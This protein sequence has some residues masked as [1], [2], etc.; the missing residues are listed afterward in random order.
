MVTLCHGIYDNEDN[1]YML[2]LMIFKLMMMVLFV[3]FSL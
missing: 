3:S 2:L 1:V